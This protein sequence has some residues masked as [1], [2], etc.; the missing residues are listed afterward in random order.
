MV[1]GAISID[2][3]AGPYP[4]QFHST[5]DSIERLPSSMSNPLADEAPGPFAY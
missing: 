3:S 1:S 2:Y 4:V 5:E